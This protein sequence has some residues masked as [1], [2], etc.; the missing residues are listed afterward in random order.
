[1]GYMNRNIAI[2]RIEFLYVNQLKRRKIKVA[3]TNGTIIYIQPCHDSYE[4]YGGTSDELRLTVSIAERF[5][6]W[7]HGKKET[8]I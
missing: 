4:Q 5:N 6:S 1:M 8:I 7:L 2:R 3:L